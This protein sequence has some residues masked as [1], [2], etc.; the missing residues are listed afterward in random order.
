[1]T[2]SRFQQAV[3]SKVGAAVGNYTIIEPISAGGMGAV[4][5][6]SHVL[7]GRSAAVKLLRPD[8]TDNRELVA[9]FFT[10]AKAASAIHHP[11]IVEVFDFGYTEDGQ[12]Y[13]VMELLDGQ[14]LSRRLA[15]RKRFAE[16][17]AGLI[18][19]GIAGAL[20]AAHAKGIIHRDLKPD[21]IMLVPDPDVPFGERPK[22]LDFGI[23]KL[24]EELSGTRSG[25]TR[26][27]ALIG[28]PQYMAPEQAQS[29]TTIDHR[30]DLYSL[31][32]ILYEMLVGRPPFVAE[33]AGEVIALHLFATPTPVSEQLS[34]IAPGLE[35]VVM[36]LL[37]KDPAKRFQRA[38]EVVDAL[39]V[40]V[41]RLSTE[42]AVT[43]MPGV[44]ELL[45]ASPTPRPTASAVDAPMPKLPIVPTS[46][47]QLTPRR[48][49]ALPAMIA[50]TIAAVG[51]GVAVWIATSARGGADEP[52]KT[53]APVVSAPTPD[54]APTQ[55][56]EPGQ[57]PAV[58][59]SPPTTPKP[60]E[61]P[62]QA[63]PP[64]TP[65][66]PRVP[67]PTAGSAARPH[68]DDKHDDSGHAIEPN[69]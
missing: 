49:S 55:V 11:G 57:P 59:E 4:Y 7:L 69:L 20:G 46:S 34:S 47:D 8:L 17:H 56:S 15:E 16:V 40:M 67:T 23:A 30:A 45:P 62:N 13:L 35:D 38:A 41:G 3:L 26:T 51:V 19:R 36:R 24:S 32:C 53:P 2:D 18:A 39:G 33:G 29:A 9:R 22:V 66:R 6:A 48:R 61:P 54:A 68:A 63:R 1:M 37:D 64:A 52:G 31:G 42:R 10:E 21:N 43:R 14:A 25:H 12:A 28:T 44:S 27:G 60:T 50:A 5:R 65:S 58:V